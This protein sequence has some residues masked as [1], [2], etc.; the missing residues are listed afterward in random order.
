V[1]PML[2]DFVLAN[3]DAIITS[4]RTRV[5]A[6]KSPQPSAAELQNGIPAFLDQLADALRLAEA[7]DRIDHEQIGRSAGRHGQDL[8]R[9]GLT[10]GKSFT[11]TETSAKRSPSSP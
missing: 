9:M 4:T 8:L 2:A 6:R 3:R 7:T 1:L 5:A 11:T 10:V